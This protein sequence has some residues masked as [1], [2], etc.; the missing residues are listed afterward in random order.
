MMPWREL[1]NGPAPAEKSITLDYISPMFPEVIIYSFRKRHWAIVASSVAVLLLKLTTT[2]STGL[3]QLEPTQ[4]EVDKVRINITSKFDASEFNTEEQTIGPIPGTIVYGALSQGLQYPIGTSADVALQDFSPSNPTPRNGVYSSEILGFS[5]SFDCE[6]LTIT[7][8]SITT[9]SLPWYSIGAK[10]YTVN[11]TAADCKIDGAIVARTADHHYLHRENVTQNFQG[12]F[13]NYT[14]NDGVDNSLD[15]D[16]RPDHTSYPDHRYLITMADLRWIAANGTGMDPKYYWLQSLTAVLCRPSYTMNTYLASKSVQRNNSQTTM[17]S[18]LL[19]KGSEGLAKLTIGKLAG[20][21][22]ETISNTELGTG[23]E[24]YVVLPVPSFFRFLTTMNDGSR[25]EPF[26]DDKLLKRLSSTVWNAVAVQFVRQYIMAPTEE[27]TLGQAAYSEMRLQVKLLSTI[28]MAALLGMAC[29]TTLCIWWFRPKTNLPRDPSP[30]AALVT[31]LAA[32]QS[33]FLLLTTALSIIVAVVLI[34]LQHVSDNTQGLVDVTPD[35]HVLPKYIPAL[36]MLII[37]ALFSSI[38]GTSA[39]FAPFSKLKKGNASA[40]TSIELSVT[41]KLLTQA[42]VV[43]AKGRS[44]HY[45]LSGIALFLAGF[46]TIIVSGLYT[47]A[48]V[49]VNEM[50]TLTEVD[51]FN[52]SQGNLAIDDNSAAA[53]LGLLQYSNLTY[54]HWTYENLVLNKLNA[55]RNFGAEGTLSVN[56]TAYRAQLDCTTYLTHQKTLHKNQGTANNFEIEINTTVPIQCAHSFTEEKT[57][58][59]SQHYYIPY[60]KSGTYI[61]HSSLLQ[62]DLDYSILKGDGAVSTNLGN[63]V[64]LLYQD[65]PTGNFGCPTFGFSLGSS[66]LQESGNST[67]VDTAFTAVMCYQTLEQVDTNVT[68]HASDMSIDT[69]HPPVPDESTVKRIQNPSTSSDIWEWHI[70]SFVANLRD[71]KENSAVPTLDKKGNL[72]NDVDGFIQTLVDGRDGVPFEQLVGEE[73]Q[74]Y[75]VDA[76][77]RL[78]SEYMAQAISTNMRQT[79]TQGDASNARQAQLINSKRWRLRQNPGPAIALEALLFVLAAASL[80]ITFLWDRNEVLPHNPCSIAGTATLLAGSEL[81]TR[82]YIPEGA[83]LLSA[84]ERKAAGLFNNLKLRIGR[85]E[86]AAYPAETRVGIHVE[87]SGVGV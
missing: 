9:R 2:F 13:Q 25:L 50:L 36:V 67:L 41:N 28:L 21:I 75:L 86:D 30:V 12:N 47:V 55:P 35:S 44:F 40:A 15:E 60:N 70:N 18:K 74:H 63:G 57:T 14:C 52:F 8:D 79:I 73:N 1:G 16:M 7:N 34:V 10:F 84:K 85:Y 17:T 23:D 20:A 68:F 39:I 42:I 26:M 3:I 11:I 29:C 72:L 78:Y 71:L 49:P 82:R 69:T 54:P 64:S 80:A 22:T 46:L 4:F 51:K 45:M 43:S 33:W 38:E 6:T 24:D 83:E 37:A 66:T 32:T 62:W 56:V 59:W 76:A 87:S 81:C 31:L 19:H 5:P 53:T 48:S 27:A 58:N 77:S 65:L 61:G